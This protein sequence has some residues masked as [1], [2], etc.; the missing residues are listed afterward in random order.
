MIKIE[1]FE[2]FLFKFCTLDIY[3]CIMDFAMGRKGSFAL[4]DRIGHER[5][6]HME[7][8]HVENPEIQST[9]SLSTPNS[10]NIPR[11]GEDGDTAEAVPWNFYQLIFRARTAINNVFHIF[12]DP[13]SGAVFVSDS[14]IFHK[15]HPKI[16]RF[17][18]LNAPKPKIQKLQIVKSACWAAAKT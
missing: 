2:C 8:P 6:T 7:L 1:Q 15:N 3:Q 16:H 18:E 10:R 11:S 9:A 17:L 4:G 13:F 12:R 5:N 14:F